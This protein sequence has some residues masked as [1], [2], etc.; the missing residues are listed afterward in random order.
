M[1]PP[2]T[3]PPNNASQQS[4]TPPPSA[5][6][7]LE[8]VTDSVELD[9]GEVASLLEAALT[10]LEADVDDDEAAVTVTGEELYEVLSGMGRL[11]M[12]DCMDIVASMDGDGDGAVNLEDLRL[13]VQA[14]VV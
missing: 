6:E 14:L 12:Q 2:Q 13:I 3:Q 1:T 9:A 5:E 8:M 11:S 7:F 4:A 10:A